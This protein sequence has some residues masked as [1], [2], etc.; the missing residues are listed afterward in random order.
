[1]RQSQSAQLL[2]T[3]HEKRFQ[4]KKMEEDL[5]LTKEQKEKIMDEILDMHHR[6]YDRLAEI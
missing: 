6:V 3:A 5:E 1:M 2:K 4:M